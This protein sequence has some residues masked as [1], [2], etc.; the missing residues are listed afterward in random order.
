[1]HWY[2]GIG[3]ARWNSLQDQ[4]CVKEG[5]GWKFCC[6]QVGVRGGRNFVLS[7]HWTVTLKTMMA[8]RLDGHFIV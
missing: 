3:T 4:F 5:T 1:M 7:L 8:R 6:G 2:E